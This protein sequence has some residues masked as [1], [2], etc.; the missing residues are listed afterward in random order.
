[1]A[2]SFPNES[3]DYRRARNELLD[4]EI[5]L[6]RHVERVAELRRQLP[7]GGKVPEDYVFEEGGRDLNDRSTS[8]RVRMSELFEP[9]KD[10]LM[11]YSFMY[12]P[13]MAAPCPMCSS[14][15]D[16][17]NAVAPHLAERINFAVVAKSPVE[18]IREFARGRGWDGVRFL[19]S[20]GNT[21][22][23]DYHG[24]MP[25][26]A[27]MPMMNVF[28]RRDGAV[29]HFAGSELLYAPADP[30][31]DPRHIDITWPL[32]NL[33]DLTPEGRGTKWYPTLKY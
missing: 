29:H 2:A 18:R 12:G 8:R 25:D 31:Q 7:P 24:E 16:G 1:M 3:P 4:A 13:A 10:T 23:R 22:N 27:Q 26:G 21:F 32:W 19:S 6:R 5:D 17:F 20:G 30:G 28:V 14:L 9:G 15:I 33:L 11:L